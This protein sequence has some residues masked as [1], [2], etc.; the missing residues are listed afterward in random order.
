MEIDQKT[1][2]EHLPGIVQFLEEPIA[3]SSIVPMYFVC[4]RAREDV[5][6]ALIGQG[7][8]EL[9]GGYPRHVGIRYGG[10]WRQ[11]PGWISNPIRR[12]KTQQPLG[13]PGLNH[14]HVMDTEPAPIGFNL[15]HALFFLLD[16]NDPAVSDEQ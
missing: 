7:P 5:K 14:V 10:Y 13:Q 1:F 12:R 4:Q 6:V 15:G 3:A 8:D 9:F 16:G 11:A 2:E